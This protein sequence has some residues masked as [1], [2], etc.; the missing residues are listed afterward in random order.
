MKKI[1]SITA[2][3]A[4]FLGLIFSQVF[5][6]GSTAEI[7]AK[8]TP[9]PNETELGRKPDNLE[10]QPGKQENK[11]KK[12][13]KTNKH[14]GKKTIFRGV[15]SSFEGSVLELSVKNGESVK[16]S[17]DPNITEVKTPGHNT[18]EATIQVGQQVLVQAVKTDQDNY[19]ALRVQIKPDKP[20]HIHR[21]GEVTDYQPG[22]S[23]TVT[24]KKGSTT[25]R[26][27]EGVK[28]LPA[29]R[30]DSLK[31]GS[32]VTI[33][34]PRDPNGGEPVAMGIVVHPEK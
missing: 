28:I 30:A 18:G 24:D 12:A 20:Q 14:A 33:I 32:W 17:Y 31:D 11:E 19:T 5:A 13:D 7:A 9:K 1:A 21:V 26:I 6:S 15:V 27:A 8:R 10:N 23:I 29:E 2:V 34:S 22:K 4:L 3:V 16:I 25:F